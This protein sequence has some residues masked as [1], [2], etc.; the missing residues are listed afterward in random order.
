MIILTRLIFTIINRS[1]SQPCRCLT[2]ISV[3]SS[4]GMV[5]GAYRSFVGG[6]SGETPRGKLT[7]STFIRGSMLRLQ[8]QDS[9]RMYHALATG[10]YTTMLRTTLYDTGA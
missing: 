4:G 6:G 8:V 9:T 10:M 5:S 7:T 2:S 1:V 3:S